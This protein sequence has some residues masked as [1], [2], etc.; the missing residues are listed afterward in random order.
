MRITT[1]HGLKFYLTTQGCSYYDPRTQRC[2]DAD[3]A[4]VDLA[5][6]ALNRLSVPAAF[7]LWA[8]ARH[9]GRID[10]LDGR[11]H[12]VGDRLFALEH[13]CVQRVTRKWSNNEACSLS[14]TAVDPDEE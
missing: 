1:R 8:A 2:V 4:I 3:D 7:A 11:P 10:A 14:I 6:T 13:R 5:E 9:G 12:L